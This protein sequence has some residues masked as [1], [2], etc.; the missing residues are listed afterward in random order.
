MIRLFCELVLD[1]SGGAMAEYGLI[2]A[3]LA[4]P[5]LAVLATIAAT[6][7]TALSTT[8]SGLTSIGATNP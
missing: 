2:A 4:V 5:S 7:G 6:C 3:L 1:E 8:G